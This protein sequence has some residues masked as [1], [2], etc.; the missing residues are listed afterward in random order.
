MA[1]DNVDR[2]KI[3]AHCSADCSLIK[4][5]IFVHAISQ[6]LSGGLMHT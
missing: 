1:V 4:T 5:V 2:L 3:C 6:S